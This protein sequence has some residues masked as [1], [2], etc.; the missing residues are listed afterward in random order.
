MCVM[1]MNYLGCYGT[2]FG[3]VPTYFGWNLKLKKNPDLIF[4][5]CEGFKMLLSCV[6]LNHIK[7]DII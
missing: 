2:Y 7:T 5:F 4:F 1:M 6:W 3:S